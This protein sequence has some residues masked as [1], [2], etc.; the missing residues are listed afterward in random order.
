LRPGR[1]DRTIILDLPDVDDRES[2]LT[3]HAEEKPLSEDVSIREVAERTPGF[4]GADLA[5]LM[6]EA[7]ILAARGNKARISQTELLEAIDKVLLGPERKSHV[8][9]KKEKE[10]TAYHEAG[11]AL[12]AASLPNTDPVRKVSIISRGRA[13]GYTLKLPSED[14]HLKTKTE[15]EEEI[16]VLLGGLAAEKLIFKDVTTGPSND[17]EKA[18]EIARAIVKQFGMSEKLGPVTFGRREQFSFLPSEERQNY[19][20]ETAAEID[21]EVSK[22]IQQGQKVAEKTLKQKKKMLDKIAAVLIEKETIERTEFERLVGKK[23]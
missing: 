7:A 23:K 15:F 12:V 21:K 2:I 9:S 16:A 19:S 6:N 22:L 8:L 18:S 5:N 13:G 14:K 3:I 20:E 17:L 1:F 10:I 11:H 4:S